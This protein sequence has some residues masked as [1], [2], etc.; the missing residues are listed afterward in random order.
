MENNKQT[1]TCILS[2]TLPIT[3]RRAACRRTLSQCMYVYAVVDTGG[4]DLQ[5]SYENAAEFSP[6]SFLGKSCNL[7]SYVLTPFCKLQVKRRSHDIGEKTR[8]CIE[9]E[10][11]DSLHN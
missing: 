3:T 5:F 1:I 9:I 8:K 2:R 4:G 6:Y 10:D 11:S 7:Y